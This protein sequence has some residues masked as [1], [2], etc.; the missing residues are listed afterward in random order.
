MGARRMR[1]RTASLDDVVALN[2]QLAALIEAGVPMGVGL[3]QREKSATKELE[4]I[5]ATLV[6]RV[7]R[8]ETLVEALSGDEQ[9]VPPA[10][11]SMVLQGLQTGNLSAALDGA[12]GVAASADE[13]R[14]ALESA[15]IYPLIVCLLA[16]VGLIGFCLFL[17]PALVGMH[18][19]AHIAPGG[20]L[21]VLQF[22]R[23]TLPYWAAIPP[24]LIV[25]LLIWWQRGR[26]R[27][28]V[29]GERSNGGL[30]WIPG[31][32]TIVSH[33]RCSRFARSLAQLLDSKV[34]LDDALEIAGDSSDDRGLRE[35]AKLL[36]ASARDGQFPAD[37]GPVARKFPPFL[38]WALWHSDGTTGRVQA[39]RIADRIY[40]QASRRGAER[41]HA[42]APIAA[43]VL[44][45]GTV[46]LLY[47][48]TLFVPIVQMLQALA[49]Y[50]S[51]SP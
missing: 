4:H 36:A 14:S 7:N 1:M 22:L 23:D 42:L 45:G 32:T 9:D 38:R 11:R 5:N 43:L 8:G 6:R 21:R 17:V 12:M 50:V 2:E 51:D 19:G 48:L 46:T 18:A 39:L 47:G 13:P 26:T 41:I 30:H 25:I 15:F 27:Q 49:S 16:Y 44:L 10:Y 3:S 31:A 40:H 33:E 37:D 29:F 24:I 35:G 20:G 34:L 28:V